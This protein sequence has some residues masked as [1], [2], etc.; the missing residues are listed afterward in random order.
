M[1]TLASLTIN[2][3]GFLKLPVGTTAERPG[4]LA[5][6]MMRKN[7]VTGNTEVYNGT[8]WRQI[9]NNRNIVLG[10]T[11]TLAARN[12]L[13]ILAAYPN[14]P[15]GLYWIKPTGYATAQQIYCDM[16][17]QG[18]GWM[19]VSS[20]NARDSTIPGSTSRHAQQYELDRPGQAGPLL[21][22]AAGSVISPNWDYI[23]G[24]MINSLSFRQARI[25]LFGAVGTATTTDGAGTLQTATYLWP[26]ES[27]TGNLGMCG[28]WLWDIPQNVTGVDRLTAVQ[29]RERGVRSYGST[30]GAGS[31]YFLL[32]GIK[33]DRLNGGYTAN[34]N[35]TTIGGVGV[36]GASG[37]PTTGCYVGHGTG[38]GS[39]EGFYHNE[40]GAYDA[41]GYTTWVR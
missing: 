25:F 15:S 27:S 35:Q 21:S 12:S 38:E 3:T 34:S 13:E 40:A 6:G 30:Y 37:D 26:T 10:S 18:G 28:V 11:E 7:T 39:W 19:M 8:A 16:D 41:V 9:F 4:S 23:L 31:N 36:A 29:R 20:N 17:F 5:S 32:D 24:P 2:D 1:A 22:S 33:A 14:A